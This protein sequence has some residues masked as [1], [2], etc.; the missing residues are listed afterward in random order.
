ML[1][2]TLP[3]FHN[4]NFQGARD[5]RDLHCP[6]GQ[7]RIK[8]SKCTYLATMWNDFI[9][10]LNIE[11]QIPDLGVNQIQETLDL[12]R[13]MSTET[14][15]KP[16][17]L[18]W[19]II[20][21][22]VCHR[23]NPRGTLIMVTLQRHVQTWPPK[24]FLKYVKQFLSRTI[25][26]RIA[27]NRYKLKQSFHTHIYNQKWSLNTSICSNP[28]SSKFMFDAPRAAPEGSEIIDASTCIYC[29]PISV[30]KTQMSSFFITELY[31][32]NQVVFNETEFYYIGKSVY[33]HA[34][35]KVFHD[36]DYQI[37]VRDSQTFVHVCANKASYV[38]VRNPGIRVQVTVRYYNVLYSI[39]VLCLL[40]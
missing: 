15:S 32:C 30:N 13:R 34:I 2:N 23:E 17:W 38:P 39:V 22:F 7:R 8:D 1:L 21:L 6:T 12:A 37:V 29:Q 27:L 20:H 10:H 28:E 33:I 26:E 11:I 16:Y 36:L 5:C 24:D 40:H 9:V 4:T 31:Y 19:D 3:T 14:H 18:D 25:D 35:N